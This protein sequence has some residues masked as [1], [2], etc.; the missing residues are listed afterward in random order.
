MWSMQAKDKTKRGDFNGS[1]RL[2]G[3]ELVEF[4]K[5]NE[6]W[7]DRVELPLAKTPSLPRE[8][9]QDKN[10]QGSLTILGGPAGLLEKPPKC[11]ELTVVKATDIA[12]TDMMGTASPFCIV[13]WNHSVIGKTPVAKK[14]LEPDWSDTKFNISCTHNADLAADSVLKVEVFDMATLGVGEFMG[15]VVLEG[16]EVVKLLCQ[17]YAVSKTYELR[18]D[19]SRGD[20]KKQRFV[21]GNITLRG[22]PLG[23]RTVDERTIVIHACKGLA[24]VG[25]APGSPPNPYCVVIWNSEK[26]GK[27]S[28]CQA[29]ADPFW[30]DAWVHVRVPVNGVTGSRLEIEVWSG[31]SSQVLLGSVVL[32]GIQL[33]FLEAQVTTKLIHSLSMSESSGKQRASVV[34]GQI[35]FGSPGVAYA[36]QIQAD[37]AYEDASTDKALAAVQRS[38]AIGDEGADVEEEED[39]DGEVIG[40]RKSYGGALSGDSSFLTIDEGEEDEDDVGGKSRSSARV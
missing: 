14:T 28:V 27:T 36:S 1:V 13:T 40:G 6:P 35:W 30:L 34:Q 16:L 11:F 22:G 37:I 15:T 33:A 9:Q 25:S 3:T 32:E 8:V 17:S 26:V 2:T 29:N 19:E 12:K 24:T 7:A 21:K 4:L 38:D 39:D 20:E 31:G 23:A 18:R 10:I 5:A